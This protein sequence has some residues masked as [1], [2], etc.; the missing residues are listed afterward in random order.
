MKVTRSPQNLENMVFNVVSEWTFES[1]LF[2]TIWEF[3]YERYNV[4]VN[5]IRYNILYDY[6]LEAKI[7]IQQNTAQEMLNTCWLH[8][9]NQL[10]DVYTAQ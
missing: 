2:C 4:R 3:L 6:E 5:A 9:S 10:L 1:C 7:V 8:S